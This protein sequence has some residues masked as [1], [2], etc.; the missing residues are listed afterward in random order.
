M[1]DFEKKLCYWTKK[2]VKQTLTRKYNYYYAHQQWKKCCQITPFLK[3]GAL[4]TNRVSPHCKTQVSLR[5]QPLFYARHRGLYSQA[6][7]KYASRLI[8]LLPNRIIC[9]ALTHDHHVQ[10]TWCWFGL[11]NL[12]IFLISIYRLGREGGLAWGEGLEDF[13]L[14]STW[15]WKYEGGPLG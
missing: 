3:E 11:Y 4:Y 14:E 6:K 7:H 5:I 8:Y 10:C 9:L 12:G 13:D 2:K 15:F 1:F